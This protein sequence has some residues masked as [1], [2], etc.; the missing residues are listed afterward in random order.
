MHKQ[1]IDKI[2]QQ[3]EEG[4]DLISKKFFQTRKY[5][6]GEMEFIKKYTKTED[7]VLDYGCGNGRLLGLF[8]NRKIKYF[9]VDVSKKLIDYARKEY[10]GKDDVQFKKISS[11]QVSLAFKNNYFKTIYAVAVFHH[12]PDKKFRLKIAKELHR[13]VASDGY[14]IISVWN[15]WQKKYRKNIFR[16][17]IDKI[18][19]KS[20]LDWND[21]LISFTDN[22]SNV[23]NR[24]HHAFTKR[25]LIKLF[26]QV[27]FKIEKCELVGGNI[28]LVGKKVGRYLKK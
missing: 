10:Y 28:L 8:A 11:S 5:F 23:F 2:L 6:W 17:W 19:G 25:E 3:V 18:L 24:Y 1:D 7:R 9:G 27:G 20:E 21:C 16:N 12:L 13:I 22:D 15:L 26:R 14:I 4:Y